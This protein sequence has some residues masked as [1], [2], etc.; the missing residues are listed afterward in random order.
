MISHLFC[1]TARLSDC[2]QGAL[3]NLRQRVRDAMTALMW[4]PRGRGEYYS[5]DV[6]ARGYVVSKVRRIVQR[7]SQRPQDWHKGLRTVQGMDGEGNTYELRATHSDRVLLKEVASNLVLVGVGDHEVVN[8]YVA[9]KASQRR[10]D[11]KIVLPAPPEFDPATADALYSDFDF[12]AD[13]VFDA[14]LDHSWLTFMAPEQVSA[15][16]TLFRSLV[17]RSITQADCHTGYLRGGAGTGKTVVLLNLAVQLHDA[18]IPVHLAC[19]SAVRRFLKER[20][21]LNLRPIMDAQPVAGGV[22]LVDDPDSVP[23]IHRQLRIARETGVAGVVLAFD[24]LQWTDKKSAGRYANLPS[25]HEDIT[26]STCYRQSAELSKLALSMVS[27]IFDRSSW[28]SDKNAIATERAHL[29]TLLDTYLRRLTW[30]KS[31][32]RIRTLTSPSAVDYDEEIKMRLVDRWDRWTSLPQ[33]LVLEDR[34]R[35]V[36]LPR[37]VRQSLSSHGVTFRVADLD[38]PNDYRGLDFQS[39]WISMS[40]VLHNRVQTG[41]TGLSAKEWESLTNL[42]IALTRAKDETVIIVS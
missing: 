31:G 22:L 4:T 37:K 6:G 28:R 24:P 8:R 19:S 36:T 15:C 32:G 17:L 38:K 42:H 29:E 16:A 21:R 2:C 9:L 18:G 41:Q 5:Y 10:E 30:P 35:G 23:E 25:A 39:V 26:L 12:D 3:S 13:I 33:L 40:G 11:L 34:A 1:E 14:E 7:H 27:S 20:T